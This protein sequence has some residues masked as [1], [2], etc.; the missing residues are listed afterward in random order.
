MENKNKNNIYVTMKDLD[1]SIDNLIKE[2]SSLKFEIVKLKNSLKY[3]SDIV[4]ENPR[5][6]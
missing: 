5:K 6:E 1:K 2:N 4:I 3:I